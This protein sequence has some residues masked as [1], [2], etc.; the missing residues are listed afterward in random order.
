MH[1]FSIIYLVLDASA[2]HN[3]IKKRQLGYMSTIIYILGWSTS[4]NWYYFHYYSASGNFPVINEVF[5]NLHRGTMVRSGIFKRS[6]TGTLGGSVD[7]VI[8]NDLVTS[9]ISSVDI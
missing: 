7:L 9:V 6:L 5:I 8:F 2:F 4:V 3:F 1:Q